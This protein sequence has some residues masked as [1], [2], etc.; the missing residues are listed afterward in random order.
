MGFA[1]TQRR[2]QGRKQDSWKRQLPGHGLAFLL[3][4]VGVPSRKQ[5]PYVLSMLEEPEHTMDG[6]LQPLYK[7]A[8]LEGLANPASCHCRLL[9]HSV[10]HNVGQ[11]K[12]LLKGRY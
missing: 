10:S 5:I 2:G 11:A 9:P 1:D 12:E 4:A 8:N 3:G 7:Q 6:T